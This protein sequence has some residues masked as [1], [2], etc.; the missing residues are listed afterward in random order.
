MKKNLWIIFIAFVYFAGF[1]A[2]ALYL[3]KA[4]YGDGIFYYS[5]LRS[6]VVDHDIDFANEYSHYGV[7]QPPTP[8]GYAGN[9]YSV[10]P[11]LLWAPLY[12]WTHTLMMG[13]GYSLPYE[14]AAGFTSVSLALVGLILLYRFLAKSF[15]KQASF[16]AVA[17]IAAATNLF[18]YGSLDPV[19]S[20][21]LSFFAATLFLSLLAQK[22]RSWFLV[23]AG[24]GFLALFR[25]QDVAYALIL[26]THLGG[27]RKILIRILLGFSSVFVWQLLAWQTLYGT[28]FSN[29]Y[30]FGGEGFNI[31]R[32]H[33]L[34][35]LFS[36]ANGLF[37]WTPIT[38]VG[39][40]GLF[41]KK[42][43]GYIAVFALELL[44]IASWSTW[45]QGASYSGRMF[46]SI[47]PLLAIGLA[48][49]YAKILKLRF[50]RQ[51]ILYSLT[52]P[53]SVLNALFILRFLL[54]N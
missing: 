42:S 5:W 54:N 49:I 45:R 20:H 24:L 4:V 23:G 14:L 12:V 3:K 50:G 21:A 38:M 13:Y 37:L 15:S 32:P 11:A 6:G 43:W 2:H 29:P 33:I 16:L 8:L 35:V 26:F 40:F 27:G 9:K 1:F 41:W 53:L 51:I 39:I 46:V 30:M 22:N 48:H 10:G 7:A 52:L 25:L 17:G 19:N 47:L 34:G 31:F 36:P 28:I 18:F 44:L